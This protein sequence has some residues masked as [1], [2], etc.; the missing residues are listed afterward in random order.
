MH[1]RVCFIMFYAYECY[2]LPIKYDGIT[3]TRKQQKH[4]NR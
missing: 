4:P 3:F 1:E 2:R